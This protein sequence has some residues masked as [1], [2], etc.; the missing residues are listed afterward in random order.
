M[1]VYRGIFVHRQKKEKTKKCVHPFI[2]MEAKKKKRLV[3]CIVIIKKNLHRIANILW[4]F[5][6]IWLYLP[7]LLLVGWRIFVERIGK[8]R[9]LFPKFVQSSFFSAVLGCMPR[10]LFKSGPDPLHHGI[11]FLSLSKARERDFFPLLVLFFRVWLLLGG[12]ALSN[13]WVRRPIVHQR[14]KEK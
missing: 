14:E 1:C 11:Y 7:F 13:S 4:L 3:F 10:L 5:Y 8:K 2:I 6:L 9:T 12:H